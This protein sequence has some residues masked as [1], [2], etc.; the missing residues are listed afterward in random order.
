MRS[1]APAVRAS[2]AVAARR[3]RREAR[4]LEREPE[5]GELFDLVAAFDRRLE[6]ELLDHVGI[7]TDQ[8]ASAAGQRLVGGFAALEEVDR[9]PALCPL[10]GDPRLEPQTW[11][12]GEVVD[13]LVAQVAP[14]LADR[15][16]GVGEAPENEPNEH[17]SGGLLAR[18]GQLRDQLLD[19]AQELRLLVPEIVEVA[20]EG[21]VNHAQLGVCQFDRGHGVTLPWR[22]WAFR[23]SSPSRLAD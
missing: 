4:S 3:V 12:L 7:G 21:G 10:V 23:P 14:Q 2:P 15:G 20:L 13:R 17:G 22:L 11:N 5:A 8:L 1:G 16:L 19:L 18:P 9:A 6:I